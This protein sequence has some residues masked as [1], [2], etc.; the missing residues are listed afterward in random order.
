MNVTRTH[1]RTVAHAPKLLVGD[2][3][4]HVLERGR[5][6]IAIPQLTNVYQML[7]CMDRCAL[8]CSK[9]TAAFARMDLPV[10]IANM[11]LMN[12]P[13]THA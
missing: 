6:K 2:T 9:P 11:K 8:T 5:D 3:H 4:V 7:A 10:Q 12:A 1:V 13:R